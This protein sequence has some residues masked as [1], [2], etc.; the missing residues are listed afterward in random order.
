DTIEEVINLRGVPVRLVDTAGLR[1]SREELERAGIARTEKSL[2][3]ADLRLQIADHNVPKPSDFAER[4]GN[5]AE[6]IVL[7]KSDLSEHSD[8]K[9][10]EGLRISCLTGEGLGRLEEEILARVSKENLRPE[11]MVAINAR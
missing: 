4:S 2:Q 7:N 1:L 8:W 5:G 10:I 9:N 11:N 3:T 6:I